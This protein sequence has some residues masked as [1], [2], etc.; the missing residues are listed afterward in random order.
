MLACSIPNM[1][2][3]VTITKRTSATV[4]VSGSSLTHTHTYSIKCPTV[5]APAKVVQS[6]DPHI[7][8][9]KFSGLIPNQ[10][11]K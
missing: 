4:T 2:S 9:Y 10:S 6:V 5:K 7:T 11:Y 8:I 3:D 1:A